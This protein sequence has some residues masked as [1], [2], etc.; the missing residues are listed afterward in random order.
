MISNTN[1]LFIKSMA[2]SLKALKSVSKNE[3]LLKLLINEQ[4]KELREENDVLVEKIETLERRIESDE[5]IIQKLENQNHFIE[6][7]SNVYGQ[8]KENKV[9]Y[10]EE[11]LKLLGENKALKNNIKEKNRSKYG[12]NNLEFIH[13]IAL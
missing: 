10:K 4:I 5:L 1:H 2:E 9:Y 6:I 7:H 13:T 12:S 8:E 11:Y 3:N